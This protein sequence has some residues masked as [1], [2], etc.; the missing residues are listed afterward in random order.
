MNNSENETQKKDLGR[1]SN[2]SNKNSGFKIFL[3]IL[4]HFQAQITLILIPILGYVL[5]LSKVDENNELSYLYKNNLPPPEIPNDA[6][7]CAFVLFLMASFWTLQAAPLAVTSLLPIFLFPLLDVGKP[8]IKHNKFFKNYNDPKKGAKI[9]SDDL[10]NGTGGWETYLLSEECENYKYFPYVT[11][12]VDRISE[13][14]MKQLQFL[15]I[16]G[17][18][19]ALAI[20]EWNIHKRLALFVLS[21]TGAEPATLMA[22]FMGVTGFLSMWISNTATTALMIQKC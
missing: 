1:N 13:S 19:V 16:G 10:I 8:A 7:K 4:N 5:F 11:S 17:L 21:K 18:I 9:W 14:Y 6:W 2:S 15:F 12:V 3:H 20:E 22:G